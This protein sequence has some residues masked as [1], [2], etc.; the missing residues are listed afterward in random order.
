MRLYI[1]ALFAAIIQ[2]LK[3]ACNR[4]TGQS[5]LLNSSENKCLG[6]TSAKSIGSY[7]SK[8]KEAGLPLA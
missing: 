8:I 4:R 7:A 2:Q 3:F 1:S 6:G 5:P